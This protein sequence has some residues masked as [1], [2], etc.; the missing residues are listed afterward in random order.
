MA[1]FMLHLGKVAD[2]GFLIHLI[3]LLIMRIPVKGHCLFKED[4]HN[5]HLFTLILK[6]F[7]AS[8]GKSTYTRKSLSP[9]IIGLA[10]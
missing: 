6:N 7:T 9:F 5:I 3:H 8:L 2:D 1:V 10:Y 4:K